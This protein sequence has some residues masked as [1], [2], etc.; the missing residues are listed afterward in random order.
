MKLSPSIQKLVDRA[1]LAL[2]G[3]GKRKAAQKRRVRK[4]TKKRTTKK[5]PIA[6]RGKKPSRAGFPAESRTTK[7]R[8]AKRKAAPKRKA[9]AVL[10]YHLDGRPLK[11]ESLGGRHRFG[12]YA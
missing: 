10:G 7:K 12:L 9:A 8:S 5:R 3:N 6:K 1:E 11:W 4:T 2:L